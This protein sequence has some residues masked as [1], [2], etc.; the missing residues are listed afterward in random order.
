MEEMASLHLMKRDDHI[1]E[2]DDVLFSQRN[3]ESR[4]NACQD[5][6]QLRCAIELE[7]FMDEGVETVI[8]CFSDHLSSWH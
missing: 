5:V 8:D 7:G 4:D 2:E 1:L 6:E 3:C